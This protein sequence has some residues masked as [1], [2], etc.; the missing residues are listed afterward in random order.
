MMT[1]QDIIT[2]PQCSS[3]KVR[4]S[5]VVKY[6]TIYSFV[7]LIIPIIGWIAGIIGLVSSWVLS[8]HMKKESIVLMRCVECK[9]RFKV[10]KGTFEEYKTFLDNTVA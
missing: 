4:K 8:R 1:G 7:I 10:R 6:L 5:N 3:N 9:H 2:C